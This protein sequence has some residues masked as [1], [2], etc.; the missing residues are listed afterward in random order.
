MAQL[1]TEPSIPPEVAHSLNY[2]VYLYVDPRTEKPFYVGKGKGKRLLVHLS[3]RGE[4]RK[5]KVLEE[6]RQ[7]GQRPRM[8]ILAHGLANEETALRI[9]AAVIDLL[10]LDDLTN[11]VRGWRSIQLGRMSLEELIPYYA[12]K[13]VTIEDPV[14]LIRINRL[15]RHGM[16]DKELYEATRGV[17]RLGSRREHARYALA[18]FEGVVRETYKIDKW[19]PAGT[20]EYE[21]RD[22]D[23]AVKKRWEFEGRVAPEMVRAR[24]VGGSVAAYFAKG[25]QSPIRYVNC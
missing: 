5:A 24:Y 19:H 10:G 7:Y 9:E 2:Y 13:P 11:A 1:G 23:L 14:L 12:A 3:A 17:W 18:I 16:S 20:L 22:E 25:S 15:Y 8:D 6:L 4:S 21:T